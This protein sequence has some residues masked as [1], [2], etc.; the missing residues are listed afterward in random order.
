MQRIVDAMGEIWEEKT[1]RPPRNA[2]RLV[3]V[4]M[5]K[6]DVPLSFSYKPQ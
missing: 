6:V 5:D 2:A 3:N 1:K 4:V